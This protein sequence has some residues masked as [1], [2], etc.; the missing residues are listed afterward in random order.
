MPARMERVAQD[1]ETL[2]REANAEPWEPPPGL[3]KRQCR[4]CRYFFAADPAR[5]EPRCPDCADRGTR[6]TRRSRSG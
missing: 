3:E 4:E 6:G 2:A 5:D 1:P